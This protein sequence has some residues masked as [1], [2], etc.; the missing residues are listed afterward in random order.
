[1]VDDE[2]FD[3]GELEDLVQ[4]KFDQIYG[5]TVRW[6]IDGGREHFADSLENVSDGDLDYMLTLSADQIEDFAEFDVDDA[7]DWLIDMGWYDDDGDWHNPF[8][9]H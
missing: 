7:P 1:M 4:E 3:R 8:W 9:Y 6:E 5:D 2:E